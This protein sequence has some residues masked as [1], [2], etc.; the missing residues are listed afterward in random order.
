[1]DDSKCCFLSLFSSLSPFLFSLLSFSFLP[2]VCKCG[3]VREEPGHS[4]GDR[5]GGRAGRC[6]AGLGLR[7]RPVDA[8]RQADRQTGLLILETVRLLEDM[9]RLLSGSLQQELAGVLG[10]LSVRDERPS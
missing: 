7:K 8:D 5:H 4:D 9:G 3:V 6:R 10:G 1:M 2:P